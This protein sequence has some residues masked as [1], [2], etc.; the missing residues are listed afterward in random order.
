MQNDYSVISSSFNHNETRQSLADVLEERD[1][2]E[3]LASLF[4]AY[5]GVV[6]DGIHKL[7]GDASA[8]CIYRLRAGDRSAIGIYGPNPAENRAFI[9]FTHA[10]RKLNLPVPEIFAI[11]QSLKFYLLEDLGDETLFKRL[12]QSRSETGD[13]FPTDELEKLYHKVIDYLTQF[14]VGGI[15]ALDFNLCYQTKDFDET[16]W[17][18]DHRYFLECFLDKLS[19]HHP[20]RGRIE[21]DL[22]KH[23]D[24]LRKYKKNLFLYRDFQSRNIMIISGQLAFI[25]YQSGRIG[26]PCYDIASLLYDSRADLPDEFRT[27]L[28]RRFINHIS[29]K[30]KSNPAELYE[31]FPLYALM[32]TLQVLGSYGNNG[33][34][35]GGRQYIDA[36][37]YAL[38]NS[39][40][41]INADDRLNRL[42]FLR[43]FLSSTMVER[44][45]ERFIEN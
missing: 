34:I 32:R 33:I 41:L 43:E 22:S 9:G 27:S 17:E 8:R 39:M 35:K 3:V 25:D 20:N 42:K 31:A 2:R 1:L 40:K 18:I 6:P 44:S 12:Q 37:P 4:S 29:E 13:K 19:P 23:R 15:D 7:K 11:H 45:W 24:Y 16:A 14:Q 26:H 30:T 38:K 28:L 10:F 36:I 21:E 5:A